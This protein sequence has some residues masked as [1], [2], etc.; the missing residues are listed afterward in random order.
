MNA[1]KTQ[2]AAPESLAGD[3]IDMAKIRQSLREL[4]TIEQGNIHKEIIDKFLSRIMPMDNTHFDWVINLGE[5]RT[6]HIRCCLTGRKNKAE[7]TICDCEDC[8]STYWIAENLLPEALAHKNTGIC[9]LRHR[10][11]SHRAKRNL[12]LPLFRYTFPFEEAK[13][14]H[15]AQSLY[16]RQTQWQNLTMTVWANVSIAKRTLPD[17][18]SWGGFLCI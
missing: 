11:L 4:L 5:E 16:L 13:A 8:H 10:L 1:A 2:Q 12:Q 14:F 7:L 3:A 15:K 9:D 18:M 6:E 17:S